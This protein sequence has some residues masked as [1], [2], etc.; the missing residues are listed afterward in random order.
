MSMRSR[1]KKICWGVTSRAIPKKILRKLGIGNATIIWKAIGANIM[2]VFGGDVS[3]ALDWFNAPA[4][5]LGGVRP[6]DL[7][8]QGH[9]KSL[10]DHLIRLEYCI[11][12]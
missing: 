3:A 8:M 12:T 5:A 9:I 4:I 11:Y 1:K 10:R 6:L 2:R 7:V